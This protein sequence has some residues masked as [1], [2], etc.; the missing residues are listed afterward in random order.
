MPALKT[1]EQFIKE[2]QEIHGNEYNYSLVKYTGT[3]NKVILICPKHGEFLSRPNDHIKKSA[4]CPHCAG[5][6]PSTLEDFL[7]KAATIHGNKYDYSKVV[8]SGVHNPVTIICPTHGA[9]DMR[10]VSHTS[11]KQGCKLCGMKCAGVRRRK[12]YAQFV[13]DAKAVHGDLYDYSEVDYVTNKTKVKIRCLTHGFFEQTPTCH[14]Y[15]KQGCPECW[16]ER[17]PPGVGGYT[18]GWFDKNPEHKNTPAILYIIH[19]VCSTDNFIKIGITRNTIKQRYNRT[20]S[21][22]KYLTKD[23]LG[24]KSIP[25]YDAFKL[26]QKILHEMKEFQ[27][28]PNYVF[29]GKTECLKY[30]EYVIEKLMDYLE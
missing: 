20:H 14:I 30:N 22:D 19:M 15:N 13:L 17:R 25:L 8:Y 3:H 5:K 6:A 21:G 23:I 16:N 4:G 18:D 26:E 28:F 24:V 11:Q 2:A 10:P 9:F 7:E 29:D 1:T 12:G 27:Y